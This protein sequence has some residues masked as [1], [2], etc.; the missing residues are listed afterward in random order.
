M[1]ILITAFASLLVFN[2]FAEESLDEYKRLAN[3]KISKE[4]NT[5][6]ANKTCVNDASSIKAFKACHV[7]V[8]HWHMQKQEGREKV[9]I[10]HKM[11]K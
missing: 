11:L 8:G 9:K 6:E 4:L 7:H 2:V 1:K 10:H 5:L 3:E